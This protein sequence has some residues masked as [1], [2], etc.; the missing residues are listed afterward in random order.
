MIRKA[1]VSSVFLAILVLLLTTATLWCQETTGGIRGVVT[2]P[3]GAVVPGAKVEASGP[4]LIRPQ[5]AVTDSTGSYAFLSL[6]PGVYTL[7]VASTG[8]VPV[9][10][11]SIELQVGKIL[12]IDVK[13]E[14]GATQQ[15]VEISAEAVIVDTSQST[16]AANVSANTFDHLPKGRNKKQK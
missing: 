2:D 12:R 10:R 14:V 15:T 4:A 8:F 3:T 16:V 9:K 7:D 5:S 13:L 1:S 11:V 6:P